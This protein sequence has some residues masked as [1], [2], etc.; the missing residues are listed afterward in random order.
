MN[1]NLDR[2]S[3][4]IRSA[5]MIQL[6]AKVF[7]VGI[8]L[9]IT[10]ILARILTPA[11]Y[12]TVAITMAFASLFSILSDAGISTAIARSVDLDQS[13]YNG[14]FYLSLIIGV[15]LA[16]VFVMLSVLTAIIYQDSIY[17]HLGFVMAPAVVFNSLNMVPNGVLIKERKF[18]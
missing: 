6:G 1:I 13:D 16:I 8:Q 10:M 15:I 12:G 5:S 9:V 18:K 4:S 7:N 2:P 3:E 14:L 11:E 17:V